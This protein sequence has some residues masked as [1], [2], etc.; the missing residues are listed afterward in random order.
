MR[1]LV[2]ILFSVNM[3][4][5]FSFVFDT[6]VVNNPW[7]CCPLLSLI[8]AYIGQCVHGLNERSSAVLS[9]LGLRSTFPHVALILPNNGGHHCVK[10]MPEC[11]QYLKLHISNSE[12]CRRSRKGT[13][14]RKGKK[15]ISLHP[16]FYLVSTPLLSIVHLGPQG[17]NLHQL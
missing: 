14:W 7:H 12:V 5:L 1:A 4:S 3:C 6:T 16:C 8:F 15:T 2:V 17:L 9:I 10:H 13:S 11:L